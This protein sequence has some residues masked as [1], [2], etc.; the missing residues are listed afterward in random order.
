MGALTIEVVPSP[1]AML[2]TKA[3]LLP[4]S[5]QVNWSVVKFPSATGLTRVSTGAE[6][7]TF[8]TVT[9]RTTEKA[10]VRV[11]FA[12]SFAGQVNCGPVPAP[13]L[14]V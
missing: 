11:A 6:G 8:T 9:L 10:G 4:G 13:L 3:S 7:T 2:A 12:E 5:F 1:Q 14:S